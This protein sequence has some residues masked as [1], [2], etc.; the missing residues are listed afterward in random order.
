[1]TLNALFKYPE[2]Y[3]TGISIAQMKEVMDGMNEEFRI[4][5]VGSSEDDPLIDSGKIEH[6]S[7]PKEL[8]EEQFSLFPR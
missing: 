1:M 6:V 7:S 4:V 5:K 2:L 3:K 8:S